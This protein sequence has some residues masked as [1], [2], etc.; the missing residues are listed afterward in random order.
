MATK[1]IAVPFG[2]RG[3]PLFFPT[4]GKAMERFGIE[5]PQKFRLAFEDGLPVY[6]LPGDPE[7]GGQGYFLD[8]AMD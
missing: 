7:G 1:I 2:H 5:N 8:E 6:T 3:E 4:I